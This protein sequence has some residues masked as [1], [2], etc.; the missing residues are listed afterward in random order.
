MRIM[1][2]MN[3]LAFEAMLENMKH[4]SNGNPFAKF[5]VDSMYYEYNLKSATALIR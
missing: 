2:N 1:Y 5:A 3:E 4:T